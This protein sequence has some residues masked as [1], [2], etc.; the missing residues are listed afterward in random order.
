MENFKNL[1]DEKIITDLLPQK[2]GRRGMIWTTG[3]IVLC[4]IGAFAYIKQLKEGLIVTNMGDYV[5]WGIYISNFVFFVAVSLVGSLITAIFRLSG[6]QWRTPLTRIAE[7]IAV[8]NITFAALIIIVDMGRP[9]RLYFLFNHGRIQSPILWDV[10][11]ITTYF[12]YI[13]P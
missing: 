1:S 11:V 12:F 3:L 6:V 9:E 8:S 4:G 13:L 5:S 7:I 2:F 10:I